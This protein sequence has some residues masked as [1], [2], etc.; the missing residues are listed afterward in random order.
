MRRSLIILFA[1]LMLVVATDAGLLA[2]AFPD[3][4]IHPNP[5]T[6]QYEQS[7]TTHPRDPNTVFVV[8][9]ARNNSVDRFGWYY[10]TDGGITWSGRDTLPTHANLGTYM[11]DPGIGIDL[12]GNLFV[13]GFYGADVFVARSTNA[14]TSWTQTILA[15]SSFHERPHMTIDRNLTSPYRNYI[16]AAYTELTLTPGA[17]LF[18]RSSDQGLS[19]S[20]PVSISAGIG[21][22]AAVGV[23]LAVGPD[24]SLYAT[25]A[26]FDSPP[27][28]NPLPFHLGF[29]KSTDGGLS[30]DTPRA[31]GLINY[32]GGLPKPL[33]FFN[34]PS[35]AVDGSTGSRQGWIYIVYT[36]KEAATPPDIFLIRSTDRGESWSSPIQVNQDSSGKD[37]WQPWVSVDPSTGNLFVVYYD[38]R[39]FPANDSAEVYI[40]ASTDGGQ[41]F[42]DILVSDVP[43][44][45]RAVWNAGIAPYYMGSYIGIAALNGIVWPV[46]TDTR[47]G[48]HQAYTSRLVFPPT[49]VRELPSEIPGSFTLEQNYPNPFNPST[50]IQFSLPRSQFVTLRV[51]NLLGEQIATLVSESVSPGTHQAEWTPQGLPSGVYFYRL[52][53]GPFVET[54]KLILLE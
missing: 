13:S 49:S 25:W 6:Y 44:L 10:T 31:I 47:P 21:S 17:I 39:N 29:N 37:Q 32:N 28:I 18:Y 43:F 41:T 35:M 15:K 38:S 36:E 1:A 26:G 48:I 5:T 27:W 46:W 54:K 33:S 53:A 12:T 16:Y 42:G 34:S 24:S 51:F 40:S 3:I 50:T 20:T 8:S 52:Q 23:N 30:W 9:V 11:R 4:P 22:N 7:L 2:Q 14:G 19:F 45:P